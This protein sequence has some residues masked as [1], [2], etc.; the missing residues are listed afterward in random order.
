MKRRRSHRFRHEIEA[1]SELFGSSHHF[2]M[3]PKSGPELLALE[4][5]DSQQFPNEL[6]IPAWVAAKA[7]ASAKAKARC[8][9]KTCTCRALAL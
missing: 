1:K 8:S 7:R 6:R 9:V 3:P 4:T 5:L 2:V